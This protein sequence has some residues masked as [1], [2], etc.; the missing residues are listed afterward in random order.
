ME[1]VHYDALWKPTY[2]HVRCSQRGYKVIAGLSYIPVHNEGEQNENVAT[3]G[4][5]D[6][7]EETQGNRNCLPCF[8]WGQHQCRPALTEAIACASNGRG[9]CLHRDIATEVG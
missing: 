2:Q 5:D 1:P 4:E 7:K 3:D 6:A 9:T 8:E